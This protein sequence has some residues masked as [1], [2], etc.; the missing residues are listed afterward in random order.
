MSGD[1]LKSLALIL[2]R[3]GLM[4][5]MILLSLALTITP[6]VPVILIPSFSAIFLAL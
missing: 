6:I 3:I 1:N 2:S 4:D 5:E